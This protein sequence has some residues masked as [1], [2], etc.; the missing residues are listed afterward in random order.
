MADT[1][2]VYPNRPFLAVSAAIVRNRRIL[3]V[4]RAQAPSRGV[5]TLPGG[6]VEAGETLVEAVAREVLEET[7]LTVVPHT[8]LGHREV[9]LRDAEGRVERHF[10]ILPFAAR[11]TG[12]EPVV[13]DEL[14]GSHWFEPSELE[15][16]QTTEGLADIVAAA[17]RLAQAD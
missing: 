4:Q 12:G 11:Y 9:I 17:F 16:L 8:L 15:R 14:V 3:I 2:R 6:V 13:N 7:G 5:Y 1:S 10:V